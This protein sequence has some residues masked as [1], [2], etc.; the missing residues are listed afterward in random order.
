M[1]KSIKSVLSSVRESDRKIINLIVSSGGQIFEKDIRSTL[2]EPR[3]TIWRTIKRLEDRG[4]LLYCHTLNHTNYKFFAL[5]V[6]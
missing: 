3:T 1:S 6:K 2:D 4:I 5:F